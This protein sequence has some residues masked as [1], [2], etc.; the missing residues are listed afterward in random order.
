MVALVRFENYDQFY[1]DPQ[2][3]SDIGVLEICGNES[4]SQ[5]IIAFNQAMKELLSDIT[6]ATPRTSDFY[7]ASTRQL[8]SGTNATVYAIAQCVENAS[9]TICKNCLNTAYNNLFSNCLPA[10]DGR[11]INVACFMRYSEFPFFQNN[12]TINIIP[13]L[14]KG[15]S[16]KSGIIIG[17][18][19]SAVLVLLILALFLWFRWNKSKA[20]GRGDSFH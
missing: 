12:Q 9:Q 16:S 6:V 8:T 18:S 17:V 11:A 3:S 19:S 5:P 13:F 4:T 20:V 2:G 14:R 15:S 7:I 10:D 1:E